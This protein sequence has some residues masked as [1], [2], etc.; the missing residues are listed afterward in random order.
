MI[1]VKVLFFSLLRDVT[2]SS[3]LERELPEGACLEDLLE[4]IEAEWPRLRH[5]RPSLLLAV[6]HTYVR[7][8][9]PLHDG[10]EIA[11]MPPV[12]GG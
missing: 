8:D 12:Q 11:L 3:E 7:A 2:G 6:D 4:E 1:R 9:A 5:W 10:A